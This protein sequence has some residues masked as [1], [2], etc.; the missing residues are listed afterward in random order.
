MAK[1]Y[2]NIPEGVLTKEIFEAVSAEVV[3][4]MDGIVVDAHGD[5]RMGDFFCPKTEEIFKACISPRE[6][7]EK[8]SDGAA[9]GRLCLSRGSLEVL[10]SRSFSKLVEDDCAVPVRDHY[11][12]GVKLRSYPYMGNDE[13]KKADYESWL[14]RFPLQSVDGDK[15]CESWGVTKHLC[16]NYQVSVPELLTFVGKLGLPESG[17]LQAYGDIQERGKL[18]PFSVDLARYGFRGLYSVYS[19][20][21]VRWS[22]NFP[23]DSY[24][25][26]CGV[27]DSSSGVFLSVGRRYCAFRCTDG[28]STRTLAMNQF[29]I[30]PTKTRKRI[31]VGFDQYADEDPPV[32]AF[33]GGVRKRLANFGVKI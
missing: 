16:M 2:A 3:T 30:Y 10:V 26:F 29:D 15:V 21:P 24:V 31:T 11:S 20:W 8:L 23:D 7:Y 9:L 19:E 28:R 6:I 25:R 12:V 14:S 17:E 33:S 5:E 27:L 32:G 13:R 1:Y 22:T 4:S 18:T